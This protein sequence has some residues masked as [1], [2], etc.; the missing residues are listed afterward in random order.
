VTPNSG[1][2]PYTYSLDG[3]PGQSGGSPYTFI[4]VSAGPHTIVV[5]DAANC[6]SNSISENVAAGPGLTTT[7]TA[8]DVLCN[9]G[10]TGTITVAQPTIGNPPFEYSLDN[11]NWQSSN[12][13]SGLIANV[14][15]VYFREGNGCQGSLTIT[16]NQPTSLSV[17]ASTTPVVCNGQSNGIIT[18]TG[19]G[20]T[21]PYQYSIDGGVNWQGTGIFNV[22]ANS[23]VVLIRDANGCSTTQNVTVTEPSALTANSTNTNASCNGGNDGTIT[24]NASGGNTSYQ[25]SIDGVNFQSSNVFNV[26]PGSYTVTVKDNLGCSFTFPAIVGMTS[27]LTLTPQTDPT[28]CEGSSVQLNVNS[29]A[30]VYSWNPG[31]DLSSTTVPN[32]IANPR[33]TTQYIVTATLGLCS[34]DDTVMVFVR[35][36]PVPDAGPPGFICYGQTYQLQG[37]GGTQFTWAPATFLNNAAVANP[38]ANPARTITYALSVIDG[39]GCNS[40]VR[41]SVTVDVTPPIKVKTFP[42]DT[43]GYTGDRFQL[44][45]IS[46]IPNPNYSYSWTPSSGLSD[47]NIFN[48]MVTLGAIGTDVTY[49]VIISTPAGCKGEGYVRVRVYTGPDIYVPTAFTPN[50]DGKNDKLTPFPVGIKQLNSFKVFNR[51][52]QIVFSTNNLHDGW[53]GRLSGKE[54]ASGVFVWMAEGITK[55][56]K[57]IKKQGIVTLIR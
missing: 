56:G 48:P 53:D 6:V 10:A 43:V 16:V 1:T 24:V 39:N 54:Q 5:T 30:T 8:T 20:G 2:A 51:W 21:S 37:S 17:T 4:N 12:T 36:A 55:D 13:F 22:P 41:D 49:Q 7:A 3:G 11:V 29:N 32:P 14:Y 19:S 47:P 34:K 42:F 23:Y 57:T 40:L 28:I 31:T 44:Y 9:G 35:P 52:G 50:G 46:P 18:V 25:Y 38:I 33:V 26:A 15:T 27:N 45:A